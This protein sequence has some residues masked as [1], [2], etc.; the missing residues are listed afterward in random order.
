MCRGG[1]ARDREIPAWLSALQNASDATLQTVGLIHLSDEQGRHKLPL[2]L[3]ARLRFVY[4]NYW[5]K[6]RTTPA[7]RPHDARTTPAGR[8]GGRER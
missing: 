7:R 2:E 4:H 6:V 8:G 1:N 3:Y 5:R